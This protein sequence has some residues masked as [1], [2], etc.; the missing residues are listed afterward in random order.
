MPQCS[1]DATWNGSMND[2]PGNVSL[3]SG[4]WAGEYG[5]PETEGVSNPEELLAAA[6]ASCFSMIVSHMLSESGYTPD[7]IDV[8]ANV[9]LK[10]GE[11][12]VW[13]PAIE[14]EVTGAVPDATEEEFIAVIEKAESACP[15]SV[16]LAEP[17]I[18]VTATLE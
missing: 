2:G 9:E 4:V 8:E 17:E 14:V 15:V 18:E 3:E 12:A 13:I 5:Q 6:Q 11:E 7:Q 10:V 16:A 1:A